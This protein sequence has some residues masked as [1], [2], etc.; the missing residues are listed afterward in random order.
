MRENI[1][2]IMHVSWGWIKQRPHFFPEYLHRDFNVEV[3]YKY[4]WKVKRN[5]LLN[6]KNNDLKISSFIQIPFE[7]IPILRSFTNLN[8]INTIL[9][10]LQLPSF[11]KFNYIWITSLYTYSFIKYF[12]SE[13]TVIIFDCMDDELEFDS[14]KYNPFLLSKLKNAEKELMETASHIIC[15]SD[16]LK[17]KIIERSGITRNILVVNNAIELPSL[18]LIELSPKTQ[19][20][21]N[22]IGELSYPFMYIGTISHEW[23]DFE[24]LL[25]ALENNSLVNFVL[26]G[27]TEIEIPNH[28]RLHY[29]GT[30][31]REEIF[32]LMTNASALIMPFRVTELIRSVNPVKLYEYIFANKP[33]L[34]TKYGE[35]EKFDDY[36][37][38]YNEKEDFLSFVNS[39]TYD[40]LGPKNSLTKNKL[41]ASDNSWSNRYSDQILKHIFNR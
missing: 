31:K 33:I 27:P 37:Y 12:L 29:F 9:I 17:N 41:F 16:Y 23:F 5:T 26:I 39:I 24:S 8:Y 2:Y 30:V 13:N 3:K 38:L 34:V 32:S 10:K 36:V 1:L 25:Y 15:S 19:N 28:E 40:L 21:I 7:R 35:S 22:K 11:K 4:P 6:A 20:I 18:E 14:I